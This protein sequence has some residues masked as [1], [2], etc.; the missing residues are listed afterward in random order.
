MHETLAMAW[1]KPS[2]VKQKY[3][4]M[5]VSPELGGPSEKL[6]TVYFLILSLCVDHDYDFVIT[7]LECS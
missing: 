5:D 4:Q 6:M 7:R 1:D 2:S 3:D